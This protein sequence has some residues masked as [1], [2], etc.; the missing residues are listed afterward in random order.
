MELKE[1]QEQVKNKLSEKRY[2]HCVGVM[3][4]CERLA[5]KYGADVERAKKVGIVHDMAKELSSE[6]MLEYVSK[7][8]IA[9]TENEKAVPQLLHGKIAADIA[10][11]NFGFDDEMKI[12][13]EDHS[14]ARPN[15]TSLQKI[16]YVADKV[17]ENRT[18]S[19]VEYYRNLAFE[20]IDQCMLEILD[21]TITD[22]VN[23]G[24]II[25]EKSIESRNYILINRKK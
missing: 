6:E 23:K 11:K 15:M 8:N 21:Y 20:D 4:M 17:E 24:Q 9:I 22:H 5:I 19:D 2:T 18:Y 7:N 12:A 25:L 3:N 14:T 1:I 10:K 13:V 16:L